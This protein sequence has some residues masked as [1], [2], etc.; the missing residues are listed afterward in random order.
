MHSLKKK[1]E[2][3]HKFGYLLI[4]VIECSV[5]IQLLLIIGRE[6]LSGSMTQCLRSR[7][8]TSSDVYSGYSD[9]VEPPC[10]YS[11]ALF[12]FYDTVCAGLQNFVCIFCMAD[13]SVYM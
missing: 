6:S 12:A 3:H 8:V 13:A 9:F 2:S 1:M 7:E 4:I 11:L 5:N 10:S